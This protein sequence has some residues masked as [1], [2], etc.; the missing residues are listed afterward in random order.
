MK[1]Y[2]KI[3]LCLLFLC[4][5]QSIS[6]QQK[7][8]K[9]KEEVVEDLNSISKCAIEKRGKVSASIPQRTKR[10]SYRKVRKNKALIAKSRRKEN[11]L[12]T[13]NTIDNSYVK[14]EKLTE[15]LLNT[16]EVLF[17]VV[18]R[19]PLFA[20]C[21]SS[22]NE[23]NKVC[24]N[25]KIAKH[26]SKNFDSERAL[27]ETRNKKAFVQFTIDVKGNINR[28]IVKTKM[29]SQSLE[30]ELKRVLG[31]LPKFTPGVHQSLPVNVTYSF[32]I[33]LVND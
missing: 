20:E 28:M 27:D 14:K 29:K 13:N 15:K 19:I 3:V 2:P 32:P 18:D 17:S 24:F 25:N 22:N 16:R 26:F 21:N 8:C 10:V 31:K 9:S 1:N 23:K 12:N 4:F 30:N 5:F 11:T 6:A 33:N 7:T